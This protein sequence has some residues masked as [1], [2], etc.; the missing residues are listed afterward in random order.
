[1]KKAII[2][3]D[4]CH[5]CLGCS[6]IKNCPRNAITQERKFILKVD[7]PIID[8]NKCVGCGKCVNTCRHSKDKVISI[9]EK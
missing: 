6:T 2:N 7:Y 8:I 3:T 4:R 1:M 5:K 9:F